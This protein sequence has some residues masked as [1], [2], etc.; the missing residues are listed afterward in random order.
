MSEERT[1][2]KVF[3]NIPKETSVG[4]PR[5][6]W[7]DDVENDLKKMGVRG[8]RNMARNTDAWKFFQKESKVLQGSYS[9]RAQWKYSKTEWH[10]TTH[11]IRRNISR[12]SA[13]DRYGLHLS[14]QK[15]PKDTISLATFASA[16]AFHLV[17][18]VCC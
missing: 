15:C 8:R 14:A 4:K 18:H 12:S 1:V 6:R 3:K 11:T 2:K 5:K 16:R 9:R 7:L 10:K 13:G 17:Y